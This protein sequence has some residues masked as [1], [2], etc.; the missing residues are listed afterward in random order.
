MDISI[1][2]FN[3]HDVAFALAQ[4]EREGWD[5][6][7]EFFGTCRAH[8]PEG[9]FI[10]EAAGRRVGMVTTTRYRR[11]GWIGCLIVPP[12]H[13]RQGIGRRLM[14]HALAHHSNQGIHTIRLEADPPGV[15]L[16]RSLGFVDEFESLR[17]RLPAAPHSGS[18]VGERIP[19]DD[20]PTVAAFDAA[21]FGDERERLLRL[22]FRQAK[23]RYWVRQEGEMRGYALVVP[24]RAGIRIGPWV[25]VDYHTAEELLQAILADW[26]NTTMVLGVPAPNR[27]ATSLF[28]SYAFK[29][30][31]STIRM[32]HG[33]K[34]TVGQPENI[35]AIVNGAL[36]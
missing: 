11:S 30:T 14:N 16:Y 4:T 3:E 28:K 8:D 33:R 26:S 21:Q 35:F 7:A 32:V 22:L 5:P 23:S 1:R 25:A 34:T 9:C 10:A 20:L 18:G 6:T 24:S 15:K 2:T 17:F 13:R 29:R 27:D 31:A 36:G 19:P 12:E